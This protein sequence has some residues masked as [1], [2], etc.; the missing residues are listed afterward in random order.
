MIT[1]A[2]YRIATLDLPSHT[3][4]SVFPHL[5]TIC[6]YRVRGIRIGRRDIVAETPLLEQVC[7]ILL[8]GL[9]TVNRSSVSH[10][11]RVLCE[12]R[13]QG[14]GIVVVKCLVIL[15]ILRTKLL[16]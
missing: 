10:Q 1:L 11:N 12:E 15:F 6:T 2:V 9:P 16:S 3:P 7:I 8:D 13:G 4:C 14:R 5:L